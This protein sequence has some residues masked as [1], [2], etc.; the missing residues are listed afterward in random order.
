VAGRSHGE[1]DRR[2]AHLRRSLPDQ[3][4]G[5]V[6]VSGGE[7]LR[8]EPLEMP[9]ENGQVICG[10]D[11]PVAEAIASTRTLRWM[12]SATAELRQGGL[13]ATRRNAAPATPPCPQEN[14]RLFMLPLFGYFI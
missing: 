8:R 2:K 12:D 1:V 3:Q 4:A 7:R 10:G 14:L 6:G 5:I 9:R 13:P 11:T